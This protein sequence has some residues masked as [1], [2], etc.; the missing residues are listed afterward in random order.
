M[1][2]AMTGGKASSLLNELA[3]S[4][5][6]TDDR[7]SELRGE[8]ERS[9]DMS[10]QEL[11]RIV[12]EKGWLSDVQV[13]AAIDRAASGS[14]DGFDEIVKKSGEIGVPMEANVPDSE[15]EAEAGGE[16]EEFRRVVRESGEIGVPLVSRLTDSVEGANAAVKELSQLVRESEE[17]PAPLQ[18][19]RFRGKRSNLLLMWWGIAGLTLLLIVVFKPSASG[20]DTRAIVEIPGWKEVDRKGGRV[21]IDGV[22]TE[23]PVGEPMVL[24]LMAGS[25]KLKLSREGFV[26]F[27]TTLNVGHNELKKLDVVWQPL[28]TSNQ[29]QPGPVTVP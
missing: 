22:P 12:I 5:L 17:S 24:R 25:R 27:E 28:S 20:V 19:A 23:M 3:S 21:E 8:A 13:Q 18:R 29:P 15:A 11:G 14:A 6:L 16:V 10:A 2:D 26:P 4:R 7:L 1:S 9:A